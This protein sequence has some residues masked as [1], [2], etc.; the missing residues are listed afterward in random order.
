MLLPGIGP[1]FL[2]PH[3]HLKLAHVPQLPKV[4]ER[5]PNLVNDFWRGI[6]AR[7][8]GSHGHR[9]SEIDRE[10][11]PIGILAEG[12]FDDDTLVEAVPCEHLAYRLDRFSVDLNG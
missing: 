7:Q 1:I 3:R 4:P 12:L 10:V 2:M 9:A 11:I 6:L 8:V 5:M